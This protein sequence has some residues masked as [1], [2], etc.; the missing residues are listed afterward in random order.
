MA[1]RDLPRRSNDVIKLLIAMLSAGKISVSLRGLS[2]EGIPAIL[3]VF[4]IVLLLL[5]R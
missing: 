2:A 4:V 5:L 1:R 3:S